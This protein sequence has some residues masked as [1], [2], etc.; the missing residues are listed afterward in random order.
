MMRDRNTTA[1]A[2]HVETAARLQMDDEERLEMWGE[3]GRRKR[4]ESGS[5]HGDQRT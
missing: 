1:A 3:A 2:A 5:K 4:K